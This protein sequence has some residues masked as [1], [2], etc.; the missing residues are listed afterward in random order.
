MKTVSF[1]IN[2]NTTPDKVWFVLWN[3]R[4]YGKW[5]RVFAEN[6]Y[7]ETDWKEGSDYRFLV[8]KG[9]GIF[10]KIISC[11]PT[12]EIIF[13][14]L[15]EVKNF[16]NQPESESSKLWN[17]VQEKYFLKEENGSTI[18]SGCMDVPT[19]FEKYFSETFP[20]AMDLV[21][22]YAENF[23]IEVT[24]DIA[25][26]VEKAWDYFTKEQH[27][28]HWNF[29]SPEWHC[30]I[31][32]NNLTKGGSFNYRMEA[33]DGSMGFDFEGIYTGVGLYKKISYQMADG[34]KVEIEFSPSPVGTVVIERFD[35][36]YE[37]SFDLQ[38]GG[39]QAILNNYKSYAE[40][41]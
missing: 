11:K 8:P 25:V 30:P 18:L 34:R 32:K 1:S 35:P 31:A 27:I 13:E 33:R 5:T 20:K 41:A 38:Y 23:M 19:E 37:N 39:W 15:G 9:D 17:G 40:N 3:N 14:H 12:A 29:A 22:Q 28:I 10:G 2:I 24:V 16:T 6:S 36:E 21:K 7:A 4:F 26:P